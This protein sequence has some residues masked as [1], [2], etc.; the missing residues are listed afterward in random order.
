MRG[1]ADREAHQ[2]I[3]LGFEAV[4]EIHRLM[5]FHERGSDV[6]RLNDL[7][8]ASPVVVDL[9]TLEVLRQ[10]QAFS[11]ASDGAFDITVAPR[12]VAGGRLPPP[13]GTGPES[14]ASWRDIELLGDGRVRFGRKL[15]I[16]LGGIAKGYAVDHAMER[17]AL[18]P[19]RVDVVVN[20]G[21]DLRV[22]GPAEELILLRG[23]PGAAGD[24]AS[25]PAIRLHAGALASSS[26]R[27]EDR[28]GAPSAGVA[29]APTHVDGRT[30]ETMGEHSFVTVVAPRCSTADAL[31]KVVMALGRNADCVV[32]QYQA[33]AW[34]CDEGGWHSLGTG[35]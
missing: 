27:A 7:A 14:G 24:T 18:D 32:R 29:D 6:A 31:T 17:M 13:G 15:W 20:A 26:A 22:A 10:A 3:D 21:G 1:L 33:G 34:L 2:A 4:A 8:F 28:A 19:E 16:D 30:G 25:A 9:R 5:S 35:I 23:A 12:L 11:A